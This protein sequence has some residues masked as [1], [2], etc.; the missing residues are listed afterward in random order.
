M[1][2]P[3]IIHIVDVFDDDTSFVM[4]L[5]L[6]AS[7]DLFDYIVGRGVEP[8][9]EDD[10]KVLFVQLVE[11]MIYMHNEDVV[12]RDLK[13]ENILV[14]VDPA[15]AIPNK[16]KDHQRNAPNVP[17]GKVTLKVTD[18]GLAKFCS[19]TGVMTTM[20]GTPSYLAPEVLLPSTD[21]SRKAAGYSWSVDVWSLGVILYIL[22]AG[23]TPKNPQSGLLVF[24]KHFGAISKPAKDLIQWMLEVD[25][26]KRADLSDIVNHE[27]LKGATISNR[28]LASKKDRLQLAGTMLIQPQATVQ[29]VIAAAAEDGSA[30]ERE[31]SDIEEASKRKRAREATTPTWLWKK[32]L[33]LDDGDGTAWEP[34][35]TG[36]TD[37]IEKMQGRGVKTCKLAS[38]ADYRIS[39][40]GMFQY[41]KV[42][43]SKQRPVKRAML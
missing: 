26:C 25:P 40:E 37:H 39:F 5:E 28:K 18:F 7:G 27:W 4:V 36:D 38:S 15:F 2:H 23:T 13:P 12:H 22:F 8:F 1:N 17:V 19:D 43:T 16:S 10:A 33:N 35:A 14:H 30:T 41:S 24:S 32:H 20:C 3:G 31:D 9:C 42:D 11:A 21:S 29:V 6:V 34:Y